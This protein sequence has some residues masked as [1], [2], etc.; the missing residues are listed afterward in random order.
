MQLVLI[1]SAIAVDAVALAAIAGRISEF[2]F[3]PNRI[4]ALGENLI[5]LLNLAGSGW[6]YA[7]FLR[8]QGSFTDLERW[9]IAF[10]PIYCGWA[11]CVV[12]GFPPMFEYR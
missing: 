1:A 9:Q 4:A 2:G 12:V 11:A 3:T 8:G 10:L 5:L 7:R 6:F